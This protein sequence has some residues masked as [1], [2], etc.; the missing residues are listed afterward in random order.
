MAR[1][2]SLLGLACL[3]AT[4]AAFAPAPAYKPPRPNSHL[5]GQWTVRFANGVVEACEV[6]ADGT[7]SVAEPNRS[8]VGQVRPRGGAIVITF[9]DDRVE[10]WSTSAE[11]VVVEHWF[12]ASGYPSGAKVLGIATRTP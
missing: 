12:P 4:A 11:G 2:L 1:H 5:V 10:R 8:S 3:A 9:K 6:R 7:A